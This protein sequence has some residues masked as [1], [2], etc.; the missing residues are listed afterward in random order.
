[1]AAMADPTTKVTL[2]IKWMLMPMASAMGISCDVA[3][4]AR[5]SSVWEVITQSKNKTTAVIQ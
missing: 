4:M 2:T 1:M 3:R 5:P